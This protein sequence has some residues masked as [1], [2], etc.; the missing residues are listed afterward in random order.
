MDSFLGNPKSDSR[1]LRSD[2]DL[3][4]FITR[5]LFTENLRLG[6]ALL[7]DRVGA[8]LAT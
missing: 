5:A 1:L 8:A 7:G 6:E 3:R 4:S 2:Y